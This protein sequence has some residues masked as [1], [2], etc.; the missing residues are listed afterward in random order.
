[1]IGYIGMALLLASY[2]MWK[3]A[4]LPVQ[5]CAACFLLLYAAQIGALPFIILNGVIVG[6]VAAR[7]TVGK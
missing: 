1:M 2:V 6:V 5:M 4:I 3:R 7:L